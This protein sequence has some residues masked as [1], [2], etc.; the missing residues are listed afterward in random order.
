VKLVRRRRPTLWWDRGSIDPTD[1]GRCW[2]VNHEGRRDAEIAEKTNRIPPRPQTPGATLRHD[3]H[4]RKACPEPA[5][6][7]RQE[8]LLCV[9]AASAINGPVAL[10]IRSRPCSGGPTSLGGRSPSTRG[11][12]RDRHRRRDRWR[13]L[14]RRGG[15]GRHARRFPKYPHGRQPGAGHPIHRGRLKQ[16]RFGWTKRA[17]DY[18]PHDYRPHD[19]RPHR[20]NIARIVSPLVSA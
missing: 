4:P 12:D 2:P 5:R 18:R 15:I 10:S 16:P 6:S 7:H 13:E 17:S 19:Y 8:T 20:Q 9:S 3:G 14:G 11:L 1:A